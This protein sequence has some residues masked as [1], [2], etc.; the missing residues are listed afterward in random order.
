MVVTF[1]D[2]QLFTEQDFIIIH[3]MVGIIITIIIPM[4]FQFAITHGMAGVLV[5]I[6][7]HHMVGTVTPIGGLD[8]I[9]MD[10]VIIDHLTMVETIM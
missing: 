6:L 4:G 2:Q 10:R 7:D 1:M 8:I 5:F 3:G 9:I